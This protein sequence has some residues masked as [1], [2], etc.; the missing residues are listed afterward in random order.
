M[1]PKDKRDKWISDN[2]KNPNPDGELTDK[3][4]REIKA[5]WK[6]E[7]HKRNRRNSKKDIK[8]KYM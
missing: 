2:Y 6:K 4:A 5:M 1:K 8:D 7:R 3:E